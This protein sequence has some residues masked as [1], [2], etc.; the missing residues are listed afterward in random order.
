MAWSISRTFEAFRQSVSSESSRET[1]IA[2]WL[3]LTTS[4]GR[5]IHAP[6]HVS[7][8]CTRDGT[9]MTGTVGGVA[10]QRRARTHTAGTTAEDTP[11]RCPRHLISDVRPRWSASPSRPLLLSERFLEELGSARVLLGHGCCELI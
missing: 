1:S 6:V 9:G 2:R 5:P 3:L 7:R 11:R 10:G 4:C 8:V